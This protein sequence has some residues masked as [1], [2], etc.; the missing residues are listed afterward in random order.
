MSDLPL[1]P[2]TPLKPSDLR[3]I[4]EY[5]PMFRGQVFVVAIDGSVV[6][7]DNFGNVITDL[8]VMKSLHIRIVLVHGIGRQ[9]KTLS[10]E[11]GI[12]I[13]D[14]YGSA[15]TD[16]ATLKLATKA[17]AEVG[18]S[19]VRQ[20][21]RHNLKCALTN[22]IRATEVGV[23]GGVNHQHT[24]KVDKIDFDVIKS[25]LERDIVPVFSPI[26]FDRDGD[27]LRVNSDLLA[28]ELAT[29]LQASKLI[30]LTPHAGLMIKGETLVNL[31]LGELQN[32]LK[33]HP[34]DVDTRLLSKA[35][36]ACIALEGGVPRAH[37]L[38][39]RVFS[40]L[41]TEIFDKVGLGTMIH[42]NDYQ[43]IRVARKKDAQGIY[44]I[45]RNAANRTEA[46][47][48]RTRQEIEQHIDTY[49]V[50]VVDESIIGCCC[51]QKLA[52]TQSVELA[53]V[54]VQPFYQGKGVGKKL[55][56]FAVQEA[57]RLGYKKVIALSTQSARFFQDVAG[58]EE[59]SPKDLPKTRREKYEKTKR[60]SKVLVRK[61][62]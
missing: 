48:Q 54:L 27:P 3:G 34:Q 12:P 51:L 52:G 35:K 50:Y 41:L 36:E 20:L 11:R 39:G 31:P 29:G 45:L 38:D 59:G 21:T 57:Q 7:D 15:P 25:L 17:S 2:I 23:L 30:F 24:G 9:L 26:C 33:K 8:A 10:E 6:D 60:G 55:A 40:G 43:Q 49:Y 58:F 14:A 56:E 18:Q 44:Q 28:T 1:P 53:A 62:V 32:T 42:A 37:I 46:V 47:V 61:L 4:L 13:S 19:L 22:S 16:D 5:V